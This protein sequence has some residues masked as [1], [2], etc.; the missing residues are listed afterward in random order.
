MVI[1]IVEVDTAEQ[2]HRGGDR[3]HAVL[4]LLAK[5]TGQREVAEVVGADV[6]FE[7]I[8]GPGQQ[9]HA[10]HASVV[11]QHVNGFHRIGECPH[12]GQ[13]AEV[14]MT[15]LDVAGHV[16]QDPLAFLDV[17]ARDQHAV[18]SLCAA[19]TPWPYPRRC[20]RP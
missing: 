7:A 11:H 18:A 14:Q 3:D 4:D 5:L 9:W 8:G 2:V 1:E 17:A 6:G 10:H 13:V 12:A 20:C 16:G 15:N 19:P